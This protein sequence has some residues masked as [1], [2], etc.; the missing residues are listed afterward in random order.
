MSEARAKMKGRRGKLAPANMFHADMLDLGSGI[1]PLS[2]NVRRIAE[3]LPINLSEF[4][5]AVQD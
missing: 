4:R 3:P 2:L 5:C 1:K